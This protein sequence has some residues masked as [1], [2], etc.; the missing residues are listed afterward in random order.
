MTYLVASDLP[1]RPA[2]ERFRALLDSPG[3]LQL[4]GAHNGQAALQA[5]A[6]GFEGLYLSGAAMTASMGLPD[7]GIITVD[8]VCFF[9]RQIARASGLPL[10]VDGD[11][12]YGEAL[13]VM[14]MVRAFEEA[15]AG[16]VHIEDQLLPKKCGHL[17]DKK[18]ADA[19]DMAAKVAAAARAR[20]HLVLVARTDA[21]ASE[22]I[23]G[24][25]A[26]ARLYLEAGADAIFPEALTTAEMFR[27]FA[28]RMPGAKLLANMTEFGRT[29]FFTA[30]EFEEMGYSMVIWPVS[31]LRVANKAQEE[32]Y[33]AI[34]RDGGTQKMIERM[35]TRAELYAT[36]GYGDYE[37]LDASIV[38]TVV[39]QGMPQKG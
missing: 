8:E 31:S 27:E 2:G 28:R 24:A 37:A 4:P 36:I 32:L 22:G 34:R 16:A 29:P 23:D 18:L 9:I 1:A 12:G 14:H 7:L 13:N 26:R 6:A 30:S 39:P 25:V 20:R 38:R 10:L 11:T 17:N 35:Q 15:G 19:H 5:R 21:A 33:A 3:I